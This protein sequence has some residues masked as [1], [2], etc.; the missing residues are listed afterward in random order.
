[1][2]REAMAAPITPIPIHPIRVS[3]GVIGFGYLLPMLPSLRSEES[4]T[5]GKEF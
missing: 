3:D 4:Y 5:G 2:R 1:M